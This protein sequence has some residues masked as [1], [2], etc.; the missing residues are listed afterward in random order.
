MTLIPSSFI[1]NDDAFAGSLFSARFLSHNFNYSY[2]G[3][4]NALETGGFCSDQVGTIIGDYEFVRSTDLDLP[5]FTFPYNLLVPTTYDTIVIYEGL[6]TPDLVAGDLLFFSDGFFKVLNNIPEGNFITFA[7]LDD[8]TS[9]VLRFNPNVTVIPVP[10]AGLY[11]ISTNRFCTSPDIVGEIFAATLEYTFDGGFTYDRMPRPWYNIGDLEDR[12]IVLVDNLIE[13]G[14]IATYLPEGTRVYDTATT[15]YYDITDNSGT[16]VETEERD[17]LISPT[18]WLLKGYDTAIDAIQT[19]SENIWERLLDPSTCIEENLDYVAQYYGLDGLADNDEGLLTVDEIRTTILN[20]LG[21]AIPDAGENFDNKVLTHTQ[22]LSIRV[23]FTFD[24]LNNYYLEPGDQIVHIDVDASVGYKVIEPTTNALIT[25][26]NLENGSTLTVP[27]STRIFG[28]LSTRVTA[29][30]QK[31]IAMSPFLDMLPTEDNINY[32]KNNY[33][34]N[35]GSFAPFEVIDYATWSTNPG[36]F[37]LIPGFTYQLSNPVDQD[38]NALDFTTDLAS[39]PIASDSPVQNIA[40]LDASNLTFEVS[41]TLDYFAANSRVFE[42]LLIYSDSAIESPV[43]KFYLGHIEEEE[44]TVKLDPNDWLGFVGARGNAYAMMVAH[45]LLNISG[46]HVP[47]LTDDGVAVSVCNTDLE[48]RRLKYLEEHVGNPGISTHVQLNELQSDLSFSEDYIFEDDL[49]SIEQ[50]NGYQYHWY[51]V[52]NQL[53]ELNL[54]TGELKIDNQVTGRFFPAGSVLAEYED[55]LYLHNPAT[56]E[57]FKFKTLDP[58]GSYILIEEYVT[59]ICQNTGYYVK[60]LTEDG[61]I[62]GLTHETAIKANGKTITLLTYNAFDL[63]FLDDHPW[64]KVDTSALGYWK[65]KNIQTGKVIYSFEEYKHTTVGG[66]YLW[67]SVT[68][69]DYFLPTTQL[70]S[71]KVYIGCTNGQGAISTLGEDYS[72]SFSY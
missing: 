55:Y 8:V 45:A 38:G 58:L 42:W 23:D 50:I 54:T 44:D 14:Q 52:T 35:Y 33:S 62:G 68:N 61:N 29:Y 9:Q 56:Y 43:F 17:R 60:D 16:F 15:K 12:T 24:G 39:P 66:K 59:S 37:E 69:P 70:A 48:C 46:T 41:P 11:N 5:G 22:N 64:L 3:D 31:G 18:R 53:L 27:I 36:Q 4:Y 63:E 19:I 20:G 6:S 67:G 72:G 26:E 2:N 57:L 13:L 10:N 49:Q 40:I 28:I 7:D 71:T 30:N 1:T 51:S 25:L 34:L 32:G 21:W 47:Y 65:Y